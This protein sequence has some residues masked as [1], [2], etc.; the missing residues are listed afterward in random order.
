MPRYIEGDEVR[1][2]LNDRIF[3]DTEFYSGE[4]YEALEPRKLFPVTGKNKYI[5]LIDRKGENKGIIRDADTLPASEKQKLFSA[6]DEYYRI[7]KIL[8]FI[9]MTD[10]YRIWKWTAETD[11]GVITFEIINH[12]ASIKELYDGR[13]LIKD[14]NDNR[15]EIPSFDSLDKKSQKMLFPAL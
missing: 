12:I 8:K 7:P 11:K 4:K 3:L 15:Y 10:K 5:A 1:F 13:I 14:G 9:K 6:L 2:K